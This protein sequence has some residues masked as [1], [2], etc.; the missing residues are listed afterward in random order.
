MRRHATIFG[1]LLASALVAACTGSATPSPTATP[2]PEAIDFCSVAG[3]GDV[4]LEPGRY[5]VDSTQPA[6]TMTLPAGY[7]GSCAEGTVALFGPESPL[8]VIAPV[9]AVTHG[10]DSAEVEPTVEAVQAAVMGSV[11]EATE[12]E[13]ATI[14][15]VTGVEFVVTADDLGVGLRSAA[16]RGWGFNHDEAPT[17]GISLFEVDGVVVGIIRHGDDPLATG[18]DVL[19]SLDFE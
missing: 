5:R 19:A 1:G 16:Q 15:G 7:V 14:D 9:A 2:A 4:E 10:P 11:A 6:M 18:D 3:N 8:V 13:A 12:A 17:A